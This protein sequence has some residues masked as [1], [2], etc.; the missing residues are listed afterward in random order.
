[1]AN[2]GLTLRIRTLEGDAQA[3]MKERGKGPKAAKSAQERA[4]SRQCIRPP[5]RQ[6]RFAPGSAALRPALRVTLR[7][8]A[9]TMNLT[10]NTP[11]EG[12]QGQKPGLR[13]VC[14]LCCTIPL[15]PSTV[16]LPLTTA[17]RWPHGG[18]VNAMRIMSPCAPG[19]HSPGVRR[20]NSIV[21]N[22][23]YRGR[24]RAGSRLVGSYFGGRATPFPLL[25]K[26]ALRTRNSLA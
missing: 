11:C 10:G 1:M 15:C 22:P 24:G 18:I 14:G 20:I 23:R 16:T 12:D 21:Q 19:S 9:Q 4:R 7:R 3:K 25:R 2:N 6:G 13:R 8:P 5:T 17:G 26:G